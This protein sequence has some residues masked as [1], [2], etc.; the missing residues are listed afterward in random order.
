MRCMLKWLDETD[1]IARAH[2]QSDALHVTTK[3]DQTPVS[4][5]DLAIE[6][7]LGDAIVRHFPDD[8]IIGEERG[9]RETSNGWTWT[10][11]PIDGTLAFTSGVP[12]FGTLI[13]ASYEGMAFT[14]ACSMPA[15][16]ERV[17]AI[18]DAGA[19]WQRTG[20]SDGLA[21]QEPSVQRANVRSCISASRALVCTSGSEF[22]RRSER[23]DAWERLARTVGS[24]RG[25]SDCYAGVLL[26]T[27]RCDGWVDPVMA[28]W[29]IG[30]FPLLVR[31]A[32]GICTDWRGRVTEF[33]PL[34]SVCAASHE[35]HP[36]LLKLVD[37][38]CE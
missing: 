25:W 23:M 22:F 35:F 37:L 21:A 30:P 34:E 19:W 28:P 38:G 15:L 5:A 16:G 32:G 29:D 10:L 13:A 17:W 14:G 12:L 20:T 9:S 31:E 7:H 2:F 3:S 36:D 8:G 4:I 33:P 26:V 18:A 6:Q 1:A 11:D 27:G 24:L